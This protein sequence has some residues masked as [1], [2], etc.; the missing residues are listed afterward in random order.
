MIEGQ[1]GPDGAGLSMAADPA[2]IPKPQMER[3]LYGIE[4]LVVA[5][6]MSL[7]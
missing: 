2:L 7:D 6:A 3:F 1:D 4:D 5:E